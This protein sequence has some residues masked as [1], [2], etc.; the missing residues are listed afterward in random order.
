MGRAALNGIGINVGE[1]DLVTTALKT[2]AGA[3]SGG[4]HAHPHGQRAGL[5]LS[6]PGAT[7]QRL[8]PAPGPAGRPAPGRLRGR[9]NPAP[10][11]RATLLR[12]PW[13]AWTAHIGATP[14]IAHIA[15]RTYLGA[16]RCDGSEGARPWPTC[17]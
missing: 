13:L 11:L 2:E 8:R 1:S 6:L 17:G 5:S 9:G 16:A 7:A 4:G 14:K 12:R 3:S 15:H 10:R